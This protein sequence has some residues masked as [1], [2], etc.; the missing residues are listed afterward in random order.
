MKVETKKP[1]EEQANFEY[2]ED[3][4]LKTKFPPRFNFLLGYSDP[5]C[6]PK[7][8]FNREKERLSQVVTLPKK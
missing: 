4:V 5:G 2:F 6:G 8:Q 7:P 3:G 1:K